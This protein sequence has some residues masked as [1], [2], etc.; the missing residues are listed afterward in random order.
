[1]S[2]CLLFELSNDRNIRTLQFFMQS[3]AFQ[4]SYRMYRTAV[5][6]LHQCI[7]NFCYYIPTFLWVKVLKYFKLFVQDSAPR[8]F[9]AYPAIIAFLLLE[10]HKQVFFKANIFRF[11]KFEFKKISDSISVFVSTTY[12]YL[13][14]WTTRSCFSFIK[15]GCSKLQVLKLY[16][17]IK[18]KE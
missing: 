4:I 17:P 15:T 12:V 8:M 11:R 9:E 1:M 5:R 18:A 13:Y 14:I 3:C 6:L 10:T 7:H 2:V 16:E